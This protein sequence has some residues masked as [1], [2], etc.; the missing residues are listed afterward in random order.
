MSEQSIETLGDALP[1]E[2][3]RCQELVALYKTIPTGAFGAAMIQNDIKAAHK[4]MMEQDLPAMI[5]A[6]NA[7][8]E[9]K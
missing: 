9:C 1:K 5:R 7:L 3:E 6:Y 8:K 2:I 4:A